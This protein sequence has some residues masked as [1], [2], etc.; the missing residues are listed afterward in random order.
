MP[1]RAKASLHGE[2]RVAR[3]SAR[4]ARGARRYGAECA[5][6]IRARVCAG[7]GMQ[8]WTQE[9]PPGPLNRA[10]VCA[11]RVDHRAESS[12][13]LGE[14]VLDGRR[15]RRDHGPLHEAGR[16]EVSQSLGQHPWRNA[17]DGL[18]E[19][20]EAER[21]AERGVDDRELPAPLQ[22]VRHFADLRWNGLASRRPARHRVVA[23]VRGRAPPPPSSPGGRSSAREPPRG[24]HRDRRGCARGGSRRPDPLRAPRAPSA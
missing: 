24:S 13:A 16:L 5:V 2:H 18:G 8:V 1:R 7:G 21:P 4:S 23:P 17:R 3:G 14:P 11:H 12:P 20:V 22:Q 19:L 6:V 9:R 15:T 10:R